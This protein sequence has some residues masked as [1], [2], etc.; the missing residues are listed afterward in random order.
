MRSFDEPKSRPRKP[1]TPSVMAPSLSVNLSQRVLST[2]VSVAMMLFLL[3]LA[4]RGRLVG[5]RHN[6]HY[7]NKLT[8]KKTPVCDSG[9]GA[10]RRTASH[11]DTGRRSFDSSPVASRGRLRNNEVGV[12]RLGNGGLGRCAR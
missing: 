4:Q 8:W 3:R 11:S 2:F 9:R 12:R 6:C 1:T 7:T 5:R 10:A